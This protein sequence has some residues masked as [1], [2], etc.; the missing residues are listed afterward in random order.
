MSVATNL[1]HDRERA[2]LDVAA[3]ALA[4]GISVKSW[5]AYEQGTREPS[6]EALC[7][8]APA[9]K[10]TVSRLTKGIETEEAAQSK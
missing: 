6:L 8:M 5:Y 9:I 10:S 7:K 2:R 1:K 4:A 3:A